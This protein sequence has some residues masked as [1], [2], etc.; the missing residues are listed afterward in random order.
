[1][2]K[3]T[4]IPALLPRQM[5]LNCRGILLDLSRPLVMGILNL[6][7]DSFSDGGKYNELDAALIH[8]EAMLEDGADVIDIGGYSSRPGA[9]DISPERELERISGIV[10]EIRE[11]FP[12]AILSIDTFRSSVARAMLERGAHIIN[13]ISGG[14][15]DADMLA[16][17]AEFNAPYIL[18]HIQGTPQTM[19]EKPTYG[20]VVEEVWDHLK[21][22]VKEVRRV[23]ITDIVVDPGFGFGKRLD[24]NYDLF[25]NLDKFTLFGL[26]LLVGISRK[27]MVYKLFNT[28]PDDIA[29]LTTALHLKAL[30][31]GANILRVHDVKPAKRALSLYHYL[32]HGTV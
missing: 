28:T 14:L 27:S 32:I 23:G 16:T 9:E 1:M 8:T 5:T 30:E 12:D 18:M 20:N 19:Q 26:P 2:A 25:R 11:R 22:R 24:H 13:D 4:D 29:D 10:E 15:F 7:P 6:T 31:A 21:D 17:V 3:K